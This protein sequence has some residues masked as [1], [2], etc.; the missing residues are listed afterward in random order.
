MGLRSLW[1]ADTMNGLG[2][3][4]TW[5]EKC[6]RCVLLPHNAVPS[7]RNIKLGAQLDF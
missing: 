7:S 6:P 2:N 5:K 1:P 4:E 3:L